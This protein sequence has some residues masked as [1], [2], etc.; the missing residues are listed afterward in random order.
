M[1]EDDDD[2][3][4]RWDTVARMAL[5]CWR[6]SCWSEAE[7]DGGGLAEEAREERW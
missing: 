6:S 2:E 1:L 4:R 3:L 5:S 7:W